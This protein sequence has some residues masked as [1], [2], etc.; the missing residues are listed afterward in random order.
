MTPPHL[1][2]LREGTELQANMAALAGQALRLPR[3]AAEHD[4]R[5]LAAPALEFAQHL[6]AL[7][8]ALD[9]SVREAVAAKLMLIPG[10]ADP[11]S[12]TAISWV[13]ATM[14]PQRDDPPAVVAGA[15]ELS[16]TARRIAPALRRAGED[17]LRHAA[18]APSPSQQATAAARRSAGAARVELRKALA[19]RTTSQPVVLASDLPSHPRYAPPRAAGP[20]R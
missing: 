6:P 3:G 10:I 9:L 19:E 8:G 2:L 20:K 16:M 17:L 1:N 13:T 14:G 18:A 4:L 5:R 12:D 7:A 15:G 11:H